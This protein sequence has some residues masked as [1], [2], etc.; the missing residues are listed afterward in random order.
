MRS[1]TRVIIL[2]SSTL[3]GGF[4]VGGW[5]LSYLSTAPLTGVA[6]VIDGDSLR[7]HGRPIRL[8]G[9]DAP[10]WGQIC[11]DSQGQDYRCGEVA[12]TRLLE[13]V[14]RQVVRCSIIGR[15]VYERA[16]SFCSVAGR[17]I[18]EQL[19]SR[20]MAILYGTEGW[21]YRELESAARRSRIGIWQGTFDE[22]RLWRKKNG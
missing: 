10:E 20:G 11:K 19:F 1:D 14:G 6:E 12:R 7:I 21:R 2:A 4:L 3:I 22:P 16:L 5:T 9:I 15:D 8:A 13:I 17:D 18:G